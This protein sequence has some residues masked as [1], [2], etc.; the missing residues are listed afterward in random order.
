MIPQPK[1]ET[2]QAVPEKKVE[3]ALSVFSSPQAMAWAIRRKRQA[4]QR[5][6]LEGNKDALWECGRARTLVFACFISDF[7]SDDS[8]MACHAFDEFR[9]AVFAKGER[10]PKRR[11]IRWPIW[12]ES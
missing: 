2:V 11:R 4:S 7:G 9:T 1:S 12:R 10:A 5:F 6:L 8:C 3:D